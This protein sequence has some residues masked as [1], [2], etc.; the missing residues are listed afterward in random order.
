MSII[1][2]RPADSRCFRPLPVEVLAGFYAPDHPDDIYVSTYCDHGL[3]E[4]RDEPSQCR[5]SCKACKAPCACLCHEGR[6]EPYPGYSATEEDRLRV[7]VREVVAELGLVP[8]GPRGKELI[9]DIVTGALYRLD[10]DGR[11]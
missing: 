10:R 6:T 2:P 5:M 4:G 1:V 9:T 7:A 3:G 11:A 8:G